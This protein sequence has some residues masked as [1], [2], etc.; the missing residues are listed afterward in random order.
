MGGW[1]SS[2]FTGSSP[3][4]SNAQGNA[5][6]TAGFATS[7]GEGDTRSASDFLHSIVGGDPAAISRLLAPQIGQMAGQANQK[8]Q[9]QGEFANRSGGTNASNESTLDATRGNIDNSIAGLTGGAVGQLGQMGQGLL[10]T[11]LTADQV[12]AKLAQQ[13]LENQ[14]QSL[15]GGI[16]S[17]GI[18]SGVGLLTG[19]LA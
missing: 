14:Q 12:Q 7:T 16:I 3:G 13:Q 5:G 8:I 15:L 6:N 18:G 1:L 4:N 10:N 19:G 2:I 17:K 11:G 9:T